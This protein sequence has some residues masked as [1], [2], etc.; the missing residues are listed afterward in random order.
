[1]NEKEIIDKLKDWVKRNYNSRMCGFTSE[2]S[3]GN[4]DDCF[5]DGADS[6]TSWAAY[7]VGVILGMELEEPEQPDEDYC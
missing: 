4:H 5:E 7:E 2:R 1:M 3:F 6:G